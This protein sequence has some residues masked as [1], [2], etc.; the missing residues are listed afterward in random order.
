M[1]PTVLL[2]GSRQAIRPSLS[3]AAAALLLALTGCV[4]SPPQESPSAT[5]APGTPATTAK[6]V[7]Q[8]DLVHQ[9]WQEGLPVQLTMN[10]GNPL[11]CWSDTEVDSMIPSTKCLTAPQLQTL[12]YERKQARQQYHNQTSNAACAGGAAC[13][14]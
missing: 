12:L 9:A 7:K 10:N 13:P 14:D 1:R 6:L 4:S 3:M 11:Y 5:S 2:R 8:A